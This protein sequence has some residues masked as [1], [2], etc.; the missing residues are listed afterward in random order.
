MP[1]VFIDQGSS[2][3]YGNGDWLSKTKVVIDAAEAM[4]RLGLVRRALVVAPLNIVDTWCGAGGQLEQHSS[5]SVWSALVGPRKSRLK[6][7]LG[8]GGPLGGAKKLHWLVINPEGVLALPELLG[9]AGWFDLVVI[10]ES[11]S[12]KNRTAKRTKAI[13]NGFKSAPYKIIMSGNPV[14]KSPD[15]VFSQYHFLDEGVFGSRYYPFANRYFDIDYFGKVVAVKDG[16]RAGFERLFHLPAFRATKQACLDLPPKVYERIAVEMG[17]EQ[18]RVYEEMAKSALAAYGDLTCS[19]PFVITQFLRLSQV[20]GGFF[21]GEDGDGL[22]QVRP[23]KDARKLDALAELIEGLPAGEQVVVWA[24]FR[25]EVEA[26][27]GLLTGAGHKCVV[28]YGGISY[29]ER[30]A[31]RADFQSGRARIFIGNPAS[32]GK[33][34]NDLVGATTVVYYSND[35]SAENRQQSEDR[36]HRQGTVKVTYYDLVTGGTIDEQ[37]LGVLRANRDFSEALLS[38][39]LS[40]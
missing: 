4:F 37:V 16:E 13:I 28:F 31:A 24:R 3:F 36:N 40:L 38:R 18:R 29:K 27:H 21:P 33:G 9:K 22:G 39:N 14:P 35:Y 25:R 17:P 10:D 20:A 11:T 34:L 30:V 5:R 7:L 8:A 19:A 26:I 6:Y 32:G 2:A 1:N 12:I 15:E 23:I